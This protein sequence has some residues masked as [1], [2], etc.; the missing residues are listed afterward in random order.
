MYSAEYNSD[1]LLKLLSNYIED[2]KR[3][4][5]EDVYKR[6][7]DIMY[8]QLHD[9]LIKRRD[10]LDRVNT[11]LIEMTDKKQ[12]LEVSTNKLISDLLDGLSN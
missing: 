11:K 4:F 9:R 10:L 3:L 8:K 1:I 12:T 6:K 2:N 7:Y 5:P